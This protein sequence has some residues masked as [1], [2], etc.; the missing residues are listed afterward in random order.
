MLVCNV[1]D[2]PNMVSLACVVL[3][4]NFPNLL[5]CWLL[6]DKC[7]VTCCITVYDRREYIYVYL[8]CV[9]IF[10]QIIHRSMREQTSKEVKR[11]H[12]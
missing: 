1:L 5:N 8:C 7:L 6:V 2:L 4:I 10:N 12:V 9:C 3:I 11:Y